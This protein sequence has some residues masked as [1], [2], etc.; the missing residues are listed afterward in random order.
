[1]NQEQKTFSYIFTSEWMV[2]QTNSPAYLLN[3][4]TSKT[5]YRRPTA[6]LAVNMAPQGASEL[7]S[8]NI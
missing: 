1:M 4:P 8:Q 2:N 6:L 5:D 3:T 7:H